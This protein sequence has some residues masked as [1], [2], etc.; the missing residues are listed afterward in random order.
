[1]K[2]AGSWKGEETL[3]FVREKREDTQET[4]QKKVWVKRGKG[5][6]TLTEMA[7]TQ[8]DQNVKTLLSAIRNSGMG[9]LQAGQAPHAAQ[10]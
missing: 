1:M 9:T 2:R 4:K 5:K 8:S 7:V 3:L 6:S 10:R